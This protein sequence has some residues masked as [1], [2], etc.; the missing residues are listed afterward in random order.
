MAEVEAKAPEDKVADV[1]APQSAVEETAGETIIP[2]S[3]PETTAPPA[4]EESKDVAVESTE[5]TPAVAATEG[6]V[7][8]PEAKPA[9]TPSTT[10]YQKLKGRFL[11]SESKIKGKIIAVKEELQPT[12]AESASVPEAK[13][14]KKESK[15]GILSKVKKSI[16]QSREAKPAESASAPV[17]E[18]PK[19]PETGESSTLATEEAVSKPVA[20][21]PVSTEEAAI[22]PPITETVS[23]DAAPVEAAVPEKAPEPVEAAATEPAPTT[24]STPKSNIT[25]FFQK[26]VK[27]I[28][29]KSPSASA[30][31]A[32]TAKEAPAAA[33]EETS[34]AP[35]EE[36]ASTPAEEPA[37]EPVSAPAEEPASSATPTEEPASAAAA[38]SEPVAQP[39]AAS[40]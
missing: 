36:T 5:E 31:A 27:R 15:A 40:T 6:V 28:T 8:E 10:L 19:L 33:A 18:T 35:A 29:N 17:E 3:V 30:P 39:P 7:P 9:A 1:P 13:P 22:D 26:L 32:E 12:A 34:S 14:E 16:W 38:V 2:P 11:R 37:K 21:E 23:T 25:L 24:T 4:A 20:T